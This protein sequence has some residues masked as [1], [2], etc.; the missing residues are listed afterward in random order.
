VRILINLKVSQLHSYPNR[1]LV[2]K[3]PAIPLIIGVVAGAIVLIIVV[4]FYSIF[5]TTSNKK[6]EKMQKI[7]A[8]VAELQKTFKIF[9]LVI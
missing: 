3:I 4:V 6:A 7:V 8:L 5:N 9:A 2:A 1:L